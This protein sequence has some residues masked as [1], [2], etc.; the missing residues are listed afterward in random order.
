MM[1]R[2]VGLVVALG[3]T[4]VWLGSQSWVAVKAQENTGVITGRVT[5]SAGPE[6]GVWVIAETDDLE[7]VYR[8]IVVTNDDGRFLL[9]ELPEATFEVWVRGYGL[10]DSGH[11][12]AATGAELALQATVAPTPR[13]AA[14]VYPSTYWLSMID[15]P[16]AHEFPGTGDD[17][18]GINEALSSQDEW[19]NVLKGCQRCHQVGN[20]RTRV[21]PDLDQ[22]DSTTA[23]WDDRTRRGQRGSLMTS[24]ITQW[25]R[26]RGLEMVADWSDRIAAGA[27][28]PAPPRP[29]GIERNVVLTQ[30]NWGDNVAFVHDEIA[31]DKR[32]PRVNANGPIYGV[33]IGN[34]FLLITDPN[35]HHSTMLKIPLRVDRDT[36]P[37]M[38]QTEGFK[39]WRDFGEE[40]VWNDPA[41]PHN[42]MLDEHGRVWLTTRVQG[43]DNPDWCKAGSDNGYAQN[44]PMNRA[45]RH[46]GYYDPETQKFVL[47][48][49]CFGTHHLQFAED[50][51]NTLYFSG[52]RQV[53]GWLDTKLYDET[54]DERASQGWCPT[55]IDTNGDG[56]ITKPWNEPARRGE[57]ATYDA[58]LDTRV[59]VGAY[60]VI[61]NPL[62]DA[63]WAVSDDF[64]GK[65]IRLERGDN[66]PETCLTELYTVPAEQGYRT[67]G[68][69]VDR[70]GVL[71]AALAG[72][73]HFASFDRSKCTV[74][75]GPEVKDGRQCDEGWTLY[76]AP[77]PN[78][79][80][81]NIGTDFHYYNWVD[82]F[83]TLG[84]GENVPI[85]NGSSSD[86]LL[87]LM[88]ET[89][90]WVV[91][92]VPYP[93]GFHSRGVDGRIDDPNGGWK[94]RG[95]YA[96]YGADAAWHVEGGPVEP[97]NL[98]K[99]QIRPDP[100]AN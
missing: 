25:G 93:M 63:V 97:G 4:V 19:I 42:P 76:K 30:W 72:S 85:A 16:G 24:F 35:E 55:V 2:I 37:S 67:R 36:V 41:N 61:T 10:V 89:G 11:T 57:E 90:E 6:A 88:P 100:L 34:D 82:Q 83:N 74:F 45:G 12:D 18:N 53:I 75:G 95:I 46:T 3:V 48:H 20:E 52:D 80:G 44:F 94:G 31:T 96:T 69:D 33:D 29:Q 84:L 21:V 50:E 70:N 79:K 68:L 14:Q 98:V 73:S 39:G 56:T 47:I 66:P 59:M 7:T 60:A 22:F 38:F 99:F 78:F 62:D 87:A 26:R 43:I 1:R 65:L 9:P 23:A 15:L 81:T 49:T 8:K 32:N 92:R 86:S 51:S 5:S 77:G 13:E 28:P 27:V 54:G 71:W 91:M 64:P 40:A 58:A 17:G